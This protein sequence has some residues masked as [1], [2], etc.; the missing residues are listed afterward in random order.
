MRMNIIIAVIL[1]V[2]WQVSRSTFHEMRPANAVTRI[3]PSAPIE[4]ASV[5]AATPPMIEPSTATTSAA[6]APRP[7]RSAT[8]AARARRSARSSRGIGG[9]LSGHDHA[10]ID[11]VDAVERGEQQARD[12]RGGEERADRE[13]QDVGEQDQDQRWAE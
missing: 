10:E 2:D 12:D 5:G 6:A 13:L 11:D 8:R 3:A 9:T 7:S 1:V 4:A